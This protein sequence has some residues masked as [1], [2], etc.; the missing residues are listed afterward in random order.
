MSRKLKFKIISCSSEEQ[1]YPV[2]SLLFNG[3]EGWQTRRFC[4][5]PQEVTL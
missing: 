4:T 3:S 1:D 2:T 5:Y